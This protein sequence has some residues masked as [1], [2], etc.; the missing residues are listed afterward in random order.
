MI[1]KQIIIDGTHCRYASF[2]GGNTQRLLCAI[3]DCFCDCDR[4]NEC[5]YRQLKRSEAQCEA[6]FVSHTDLEKKYKAKEQECEELKELVKKQKD[7]LIH[8]TILA[9]EYESAYLFENT[10]VAKLKYS[11]TEIKEIAENAY[12][13]TNG[14][15]KDMANFA[16][17]ILQKISE[18][19]G[20]NDNT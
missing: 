19:D 5:Y 1:D 18:C 14:T 6:M 10:K 8:K 20:K 3:D 7:V 11:L 9:D 12:C 15:N 16:K 17:Q 13:L 2:D 4:E